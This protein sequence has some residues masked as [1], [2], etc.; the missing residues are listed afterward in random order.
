MARGDYPS[1]AYTTLEGGQQFVKIAT[2]HA[3]Q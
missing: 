2:M 3:A 1:L